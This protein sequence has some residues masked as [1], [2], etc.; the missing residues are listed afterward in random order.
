M[1]KCPACKKDVE[2]WRTHCPHCGAEFEKEAGVRSGSAK[3][4]RVLAW[5]TWICGVFSGIVY[6]IITESFLV[7]FVVTMVTVISGGVLYTQADLF[8]HIRGMYIVL[9]KMEEELQ[10]K[11][12]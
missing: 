5:I 9:S 12:K 8:E 4:F 7:I 10:Q 1:T 6:G 11:N 3:F 2:E